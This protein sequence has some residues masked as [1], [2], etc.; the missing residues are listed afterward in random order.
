MSL[1]QQ[2]LP[3]SQPLKISQRFSTCEHSF[4]LVDVEVRLSL[5]S[6]ISCSEQYFD[7]SNG[8]VS[9][10]PKLVERL[11][12]IAKIWTD[13]YGNDVFAQTREDCGEI[14]IFPKTVAISSSLEELVLNF[15]GIIS[16]D[17]DNILY[18]LRPHQSCCRLLFFN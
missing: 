18:S 1:Y 10:P 15:G 11:P 5:S 4:H 16:K 9:E 2:Y 8:V 3:S 7:I 13:F 17:V 6:D 12:K 14:G